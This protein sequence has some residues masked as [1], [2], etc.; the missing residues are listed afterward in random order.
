MNERLADLTEAELAEAALANPRIAQ[1][2]ASKDPRV[3]LMER[4]YGDPDSKRDI[5]KHSKRLFP[6]ASVPEIDIPEIVRSELK[7]DIDA[8]KTLRADLESDVKSR[9]HTAFR[10]KLQ[11]AGADAEDLDAIETFMVDNEIGPKSVKIAVE[12]FY[13][14]QELAEPRGAAG[15]SPELPLDGKDEHM[16]ALLAAAPSDDLDRINEPFAHKIYQEMFGAP[17]GRRGRG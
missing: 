7:D 10:S 17:A 8:I 9:R 3:Q 4:L 15:L 16:Q 5:Q 1:A 6:K 2:V 12:K 11:E 14:A 13:D